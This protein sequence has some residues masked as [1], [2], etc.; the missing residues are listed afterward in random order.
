MP[1]R[2]DRS[3]A[4]HRP[5]HARASQGR[6]RAPGHVSEADVSRRKPV[7]MRTTVMLLVVSAAVVGSMRFETR[8]R[9]QALRELRP[10]AAFAE[11]QSARERSI[12]LFTE[13]GR[14]IAHPRCMNCHPATGRPLQAD[15]QRPHSP[16]VEGGSAGSGVPGLACTACHRERNIVLVGTALKS[17]PGH[18]RW[19]LAPG[20]MA[21]EG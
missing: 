5:V 6:A 4:A 3:A 20:E 14:V 21:W 19:H 15:G 16:T 11:I 12:A 13:A 7:R 8:P 10:A 17:M 2:R 1:C 18:P 9:A